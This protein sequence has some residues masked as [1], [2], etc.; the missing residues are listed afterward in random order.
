MAKKTPPRTQRKARKKK[1]KQR[2]VRQLEKVKIE[3]T[4][5]LNLETAEVV[6]QLQDAKVELTGDSNS[7]NIEVERLANGIEKIVGSL[8][9]KDLHWAAS[10]ILSIL[11]MKYEIPLQ[12]LSNKDLG[13]IITS[14]IA[15]LH[16]KNPDSLEKI[17]HFIEMLAEAS[18]A[19][20]R[21]KNYVHNCRWLSFQPKFAFKN[22]NP[23]AMPSSSIVWPTRGHVTVVTG[24]CTA[25]NACSATAI[26]A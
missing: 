8:D 12:I 7:R 4:G 3:L 9:H 25:F 2:V 15:A 11:N 26:A 23:S 17:G 22:F 6:N 5:G 21:Q 10:T 16:G 18:N 1:P 24:T 20:F 14:C 19:R 13:K